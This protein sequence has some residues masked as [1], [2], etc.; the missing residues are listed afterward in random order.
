MVMAL[1]RLERDVDFG[2]RRQCGEWKERHY[3]R[4]IEF[5]SGQLLVII[6]QRDSL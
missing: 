2:I 1:S 4:A 3:P 6:S 5:H